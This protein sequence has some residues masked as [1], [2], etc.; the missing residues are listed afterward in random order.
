MSNQ[1]EML[2]QQVHQ[3]REWRQRAIRRSQIRLR[4]VP[5]HWVEPIFECF[6]IGIFNSLSI[7]YYLQWFCFL[8]FFIHV[9]CWCLS[10]YM[11]MSFIQVCGLLD[12][13][14]YYLEAKS[15]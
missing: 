2:N 9:V 5:S 4:T 3:S 11:L 7:V 1:I 6:F 14:N 10:D 12:L 13:I 15:Y 8:F